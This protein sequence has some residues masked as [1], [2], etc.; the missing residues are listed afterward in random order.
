VAYLAARF[1][2]RKEIEAAVQRAAQALAPAVVRIRYNYADDWD[3]EPSIFFRVVIADEYARNPK[4][5]DLA[6]AVSITVM[7][8]ANTDELGLHAY[9]RY[10]TVSDQS[11]INEPEWE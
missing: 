2:N 3:G 7:N 9:F 11:Q 6:D 1:A 8:E 5:S 10:R 4:L